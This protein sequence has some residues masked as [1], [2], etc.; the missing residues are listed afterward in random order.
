VLT[1]FNLDA[2][3]ADVKLDW[4]EVD[5]L[6]DTNLAPRVASG[7]TPV[8]HDLISGAEMQA[9]ADG[10]SL[11]LAPHASRIFRIPAK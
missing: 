7:K 1:V 9:S 10:L 4:R 5:A 11:T 2:A 6:R 8:L 3:Q